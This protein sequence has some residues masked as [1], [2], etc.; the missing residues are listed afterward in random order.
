MR[1]VF[2]RNGVDFRRWLRKNHD[3]A[4]ALLVGFYRKESGK[5][6]IS[7]SEALDEALCFGWIDGIRKRWDDVSYTVRFTPRKKRSIWSAVNIKRAGELSAQGRMAPSGLHAFES[8]DVRRANLSSY[9]RATAGLDPARRREF[10]RNG[11]AWTFF[12]AQPPGY[13]KIASYYVMS[14]KK[15]ETRRRRLTHL[16][17]ESA[18]GRRLG[19]VG[20]SK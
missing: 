9:E 14:A 7:Y 12:E 8:R 17:E 15:E 3:S 1:P 20:T 4:A 6:G 19:L 16:I 13:R 11:A 10:R 5:K 18:R 2:F